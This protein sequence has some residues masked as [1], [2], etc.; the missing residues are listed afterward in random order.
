MNKHFEVRIASYLSLIFAGFLAADGG[1]KAMLLVLAAFF[2]SHIF[3]KVIITSKSSVVLHEGL[4]R[5]R[6]LVY[7][8]VIIIGPWVGLT[9][10]LLFL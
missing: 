9:L 2:T 6:F 5:W 3:G 10:C 4:S 1:Y 8:C 7:S